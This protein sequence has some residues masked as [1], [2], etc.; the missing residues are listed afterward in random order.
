MVTMDFSNLSVNDTWWQK[1]NNIMILMEA[2]RIYIS[3]AK[4]ETDTR[5]L[6]N[7]YNVVRGIDERIDT[8][9]VIEDFYVSTSKV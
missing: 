8:L 7:L 3:F 6:Q 2:R 5:S 1:E 4:I 9:K